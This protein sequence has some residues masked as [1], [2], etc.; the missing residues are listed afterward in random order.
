LAGHSRRVADQLINEGRVLV[1]GIPP[2]LGCKVKFGDTITVDSKP[3]PWEQYIQNQFNPLAADAYIKKDNGFLYLKMWKPVGITCT[4]TEKD[5]SNIVKFA[6]F[7]KE[8]PQQRIFP[9]GRLD[10]NSSG[11]ILMTSDPSFQHHILGSKHS[12]NHE[13]KAEDSTDLFNRLKKVYE[14]TI[15]G[16][17]PTLTILKQWERGVAI[18]TRTTQG[19][20][21]SHATLPC[22]ILPLHPP[23]SQL[24]QQDLLSQETAAVDALFHSSSPPTSP[25]SVGTNSYTHSYEFTLYEGRNRQIRRM[26]EAMDYRILTLHRSAIGAINLSGLERPGD[27]QMLSTAELS[28][29]S[30]YVRGI[31]KSQ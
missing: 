28:W 27:W 8:F 9:V 31:E 22:Q 12:T 3:V 14:V 17:K 23:A 25:D 5:S 16:P 6:N 21:L 15:K 24:A 11:L 26:I 29:L 7:A 1:N 19:K 2:N 20:T 4:T 10:K 30:D 18:T 13:D